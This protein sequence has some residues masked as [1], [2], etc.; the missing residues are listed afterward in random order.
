MQ[1]EGGNGYGHAAMMVNPFFYSMDYS[2][3][4][5]FYGNNNLCINYGGFTTQ[6][7]CGFYLLFSAIKLSPLPNKIF[8]LLS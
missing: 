6:S 5:D 7:W 2:M 3:D 1:C 4:D 8:R